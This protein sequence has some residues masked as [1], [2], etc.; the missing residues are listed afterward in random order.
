MTEEQ[1][2]QMLHEFQYEQEHSADYWGGHKGAVSGPP[3]DPFKL[4]RW[5]GRKLS[6]DED[7]A[8]RPPGS[9]EKWYDRS[10]SEV[11]WA[12]DGEIAKGDV[13]SSTVA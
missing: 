4:F 13:D 6:Y 3:K 1:R 2:L 9:P 7:P 10:R 11:E 5:A 12:K 8:K